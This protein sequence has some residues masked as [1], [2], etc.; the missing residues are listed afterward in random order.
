MSGRPEYDIE[1]A[2]LGNISEERACIICDA[3]GLNPIWRN[4]DGELGGPDLIVEY[5]GIETYVEVEGRRR[6]VKKKDGTIINNMA[7]AF[8]H[9]IHF[10]CTTVE[11]WLYSEFCPWYFSIWDDF[12]T[13]HIATMEYIYHNGVKKEVQNS[14]QEKE[15]FY[16]L[17]HSR[18]L[19]RRFDE[20]FQGKTIKKNRI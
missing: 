19:T 9:G 6:F 4:I 12:K 7:L 16:R 14:R 11:K 5:E 15:W 3:L 18:V 8:E 20:R 1:D 13:Y 10:R 17:P 2:L